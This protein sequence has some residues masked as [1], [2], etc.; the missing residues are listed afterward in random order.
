MRRDWTRGRRKLGR[1]CQAGTILSH[2]S[3]P[4]VEALHERRLGYRIP[5]E[6]MVTSYVQDRPIR[7][8]AT[9]LSDTGVHMSTVSMVAPPP[10]MIVPLEIDLPGAGESIWASGRICYRQD[11]RLASGLGVRFVAMAKSQARI[12]RDF[13]IEMR[14]KNLGS[15][16]ARIRA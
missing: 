3:P 15:I 2:I 12:V 8:L 6:S 14:R 9:N 13:C 11:D 10:G 7:G 1:R 4:E 5:F 16:L